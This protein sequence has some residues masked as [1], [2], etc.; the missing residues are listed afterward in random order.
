MYR[1]KLNNIN[2]VRSYT[3]DLL[4][5]ALAERDFMSTGHTQRLSRI[6]LT[7]AEKLDL[8]APQL[9]NLAIL[10]QVHDLGKIGVPD[11]ILFKKGIL[12]EEEWSIMRQHPEKGY[13]LALTSPDLAEFA[14][15]ILKHHE[16]WDGSGYPLGI[17]GKEIPIECRIFAIVDA[18]E[19]R[20]V[21][22]L[23][24]SIMK[25]GNRRTEKEFRHQV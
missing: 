20:R 9:I 8:P 18:F 19:S 24:A 25:R 3:I 14:D 6:C 16:S 15:L 12:T 2:S 1:D 23:T 7:M 11:S 17:K 10:T 5:N 21:I 22:G 4:L 13:R